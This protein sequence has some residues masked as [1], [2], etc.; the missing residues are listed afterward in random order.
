MKMTMQDFDYLQSG[1]VGNKREL[2]VAKGY[3]SLG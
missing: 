3:D 2:L 1:S